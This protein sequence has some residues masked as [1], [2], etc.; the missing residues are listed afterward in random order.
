MHQNHFCLKWKSN[1]IS[2]NKAIEELKINL[3][4]VDNVIYDECDKSFIKD[5]YTF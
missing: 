4:V 1:G 3:D 2:F 5:E